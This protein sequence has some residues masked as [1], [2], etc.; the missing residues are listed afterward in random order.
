MNK[1][2][3]KSIIYIISFFLY[4]G[5][6]V[7]LSLFFISNQVDLTRFYSI[8][9]RMLL[10]VL[11]VF[12]IFKKWKTLKKSNVA[13]RVFILFSL[14]Y[15]FKVLFS[16]NLGSFLSRNWYEYIFYFISYAF[17]PFLFFSSVDLNKHKNTILNA[18]IFSGFLLSILTVIFFKDVL[19]TGGVSRINLLTYETEEAVISPL[20]LSYSGALTFLLCLYRLLYTNLR[21]VTLFY[22]L[23][24]MIASSLIF[25]LGSTRG[26]L[27]AVLLGAIAFIYFSNAK[28]KIFFVFLFAALT[29]LIIYAIEFTG[30]SII[31]R[32]ISSYETG[33][34][35]GR[36][37]LWSEAFQEFLNYPI[38]GGRIEVSGIYPHNIFLEVMMATGLLGLILFLYFFFKSFLNGYKLAKHNH[39]FLIAIMIFVIGI[40]QHMVTGALWGAITFFT[41]LGL[42]N[43]KLTYGK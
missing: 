10:S 9:L 13:I 8:P 40:S 43:S 39:I 1:K 35:S 25:L 32:T 6:Y 26:A 15:I 42:F 22:I 12:F 16:E 2:I 14:L 19:L 4:S 3:E 28:R 30:S 23:L 31:E 17:L 5:Y 36:E 34:T 21:G 41:S 38:L 20:A 18:L 29:P 33:D 7:I 24:T 37:K 11:M 27:L